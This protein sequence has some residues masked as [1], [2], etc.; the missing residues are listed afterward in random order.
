M[1]EQDRLDLN[2]MVRV[3]KRFQKLY[4]KTGFTGCS[5]DGVHLEKDYFLDMFN[6][7]EIIERDCE[8]YPYQLNS[9]INKDMF[10]TLI[11]EETY[12]ELE[13]E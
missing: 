12:Q 5:T 10:F 6:G 3:R 11:T 7:W 13:V 8:A 2:K 4:R 1:N 9:Y